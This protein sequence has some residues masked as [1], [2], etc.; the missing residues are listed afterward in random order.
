MH[1]KTIYLCVRKVKWLAVILH[2]CSCF[3]AHKF[4]EFGLVSCSKGEEKQ[5]LVLILLLSLLFLQVNIF[6]P[7][8]VGPALHLCFTRVLPHA[9]FYWTLLVSLQVGKSILYTKVYSLSNIRMLI[10]DSLLPQGG[11]FETSPR[12]S[13]ESLYLKMHF[14]KN[15]PSGYG[16]KRNSNRKW[17][18]RL[19]REVERI[20]SVFW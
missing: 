5:M 16:N 6:L 18:R 14:T 12:T 10:W 4:P 8:Q 2:L 17:D 7:N 20:A 11:T 3:V 13:D 1:S 9:W 15:Q 19:R